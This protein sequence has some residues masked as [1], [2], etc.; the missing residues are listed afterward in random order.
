MEFGYK[1]NMKRLYLDY[2]K[3]SYRVSLLN[4]PYSLWQD[5]QYGLDQ[6]NCKDKFMARENLLISFHFNVLAWQISKE[7]NEEIISKKR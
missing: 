5:I 3:G 7:N 4:N 2:N 1:G 6:W